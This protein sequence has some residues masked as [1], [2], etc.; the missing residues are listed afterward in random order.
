MADKGS[1]SPGVGDSMLLSAVNKF[2]CSV[3]NQNYK[4]RSLLG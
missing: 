3:A 4:G 2:V 1:I